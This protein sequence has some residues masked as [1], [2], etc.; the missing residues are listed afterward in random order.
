MSDAPQTMA[1]FLEDFAKRIE[2]G[3]REQISGLE[4]KIDDVGIQV[5]GVS[6]RMDKLETHL[7]SMAE[8]LDNSVSALDMTMDI[9][10][11]GIKEAGN[12]LEHRFTKQERR[13]TEQER[14]FTEQEQQFTRF[15]RGL[16]R[17]LG[18]MALDFRLVQTDAALALN[19]TRD[20]GAE[21]PYAEV[22]FPDG[23]LPS[24]TLF[25]MVPLPTI[26][27]INDIS[28]MP[29]PLLLVLL[30]HYDVSIN[31]NETLLDLRLKLCEA[32][33]VST[34]TRQLY[35]SLCREV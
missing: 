12:R 26:R 14:R 33:G 10:L 34:H 29:R 31:S 13:F 30:N 25:Q 15:E 21:S 22:P 1:S 4:K 9:Q 16:N 2:R 23:V 7:E 28:G 17:T 6:E 35:A 3:V 20:A 27:C 32:I 18:E 8:H 24:E 11:G 5:E 19:F